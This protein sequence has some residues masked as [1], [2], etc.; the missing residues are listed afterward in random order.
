MIWFL[1]WYI[2]GFITMLVMVRSEEDVTVECLGFISLFSLAGPSIP[3]IFLF[4][5]RKDTVIFRKK[6]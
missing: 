1:I 6:E 2:S 3:L 5:E 4:K